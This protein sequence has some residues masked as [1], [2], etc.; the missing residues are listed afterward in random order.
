MKELNFNYEEISKDCIKCGKCIPTCTIHQINPDETTSPRGFLHLLGAYNNGN[1][2]LDKE[3]KDIFE[4]CFL[5]TN[6]TDVCPGSLPTDFMIENVRAD[7][8]KKYGIAW[9][10]KAFFTL[11]KNRKLMDF[12]AKLGYVFKSCGFSSSKTQEGMIARFGIPMIKKGRL[13]P[14]VK[15]KSFLN[16]YP[17]NMD[18]NGERKVAI[19]IGCMANYSYTGVGDSLL[20]ILKKLQINAF[21]PKEQVCCGAPA[22]F[23]GDLETTEE[24][25]KRNIDYFETFIDD[26]EAILIPEATCSSMV[27]HDWKRVLRDE[28]QWLERVDKI[29]KKTFIST[30]WLDK[31]TDLDKLLEKHKAQN[32]SVT[33][34]DPCHSRKTQGV[35]KE[36]RNLISKNYALKDMSDPNR[37]CGFGGVTIQSEKAHLS[38]MAG[39]PKAEMIR[40]TEADYVS[41]ECSACRVQLSNALHEE[42]VETKFIHPVELIAQS[43]RGKEK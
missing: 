15:S 40:D 12:M 41:A 30:E 20:Y 7:I 1:L 42:K 14:S 21:I 25:I 36:P 3:V 38:E 28:P 18:F 5:C 26:I 34:H 29:V 9:Y 17:E 31:Y 24:L 39:K 37:C 35:W 22:F 6:C 13:L 16:T 8:A 11:L 23:T 27:I 19:F 43:L 32:S 4:S 10:K 33:Y 2:E